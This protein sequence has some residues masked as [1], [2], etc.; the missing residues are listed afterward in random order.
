MNE[1]FR[2]YLPGFAGGGARVAGP[3]LVP[4][5]NLLQST[6]RRPTANLYLAVLI[7]VLLVELLVVRGIYNDL[8]ATRDG[9]E[10]IQRE[11]QAERR[12]DNRVAAGIAGLTDQIN[13]LRKARGVLERAAETVASNHIDWSPSLYAIFDS[14]TPRVRF[15]SVTASPG[16]ITV[17]MSGTAEDVAD[18]V[19]FQSRIHEPDVASIIEIQSMSW[20][21]SE[22]E[23]DGEEGPQD[24]GVLEFSATFKV[25]QGINSE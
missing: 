22:A 1:R 13:N 18:M 12:R 6:S 14:Q 20:E 19:V 4:K 17:E 7:A 3:Q 16:Q 10:Q 2:R 15:D 25:R 9:N 23:V 5:I 11:L 21:E 8:V 24:S